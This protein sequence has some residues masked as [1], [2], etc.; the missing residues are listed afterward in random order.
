MAALSSS[1]HT[2]AT[3]LVDKRHA[4]RSHG[5]PVPQSPLLVSFRQ[6]QVQGIGGFAKIDIRRGKRIVEY[7]GPRISKEEAKDL[8]EEGTPYIFTLNDEDD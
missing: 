5:N 8:I 3:L 7:D 1:R 4:W 6:S 2:D